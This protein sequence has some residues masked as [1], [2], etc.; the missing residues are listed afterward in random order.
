MRDETQCSYNA[1]GNQFTHETDGS[2]GG[3]IASEAHKFVDAAVAVYTRKEQLWKSRQD[4]GTDLLDQLFD[5]RINLP[6]VENSMSDAIISLRQRRRL[7]VIGDILYFSKW[8]E[9]KESLAN[10]T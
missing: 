8:I 6:V 10:K 7:D 3:T 2:W 5:G 4:K 1:D 9:L